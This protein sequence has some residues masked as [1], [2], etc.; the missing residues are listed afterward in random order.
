MRICRRLCALAAGLLLTLAAAIDVRAQTGTYP[1]A[2][3]RIISDSAAGST[4]DVVLRLISDR[5][6][7]IWGQQVVPVNHPGAG[8]SLAA[9]DAADA[10]P[11]GYTLFMPV[12]SA[13][14]ALP[15]AAP[16]LPIQLPRDFAAIG[17]A[18]ENPMFIAVGP[19][20][21]VK[22]LPELIARA[23]AHPDQISCAV[24]GIARLTGLSAALLQKEAGI[25]ILIVPYTGGP[26]HAVSDV[27]GGRVDFII[28]GYG[29]IAGALQSGA[30][31]AIAVASEKPL[32]E[33]PGL[34]LVSETIPGFSAT[35]WQILAAPLG[36]PAPIIRKA[37]EDLRKVVADPD[38]QKKIAAR[39]SYAR[40]MSPEEA[41]AFVQAEQ[42]KWKPAVEQIAAKSH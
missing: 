28:E 19:K 7:Q 40:A 33:F 21:G 15:G 31:K 3:V 34:P 16:N 22:T 20:L 25:K 23:K 5:L 24:T 37:S 12:L 32:A 11:D 17:F 29:G 26:A 39:G 14:V 35:G 10:A 30:I 8:G 6:S 36:T 41:T 27:V 13:F 9:R 4:P 42:R 1:N 2:P 18:A 38:F